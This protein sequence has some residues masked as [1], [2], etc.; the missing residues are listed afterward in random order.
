[1]VS[2]GDF[3]EKHLNRQPGVRTGFTFSGPGPIR[4]RNAGRVLQ[5]TKKMLA[6]QS[7]LGSP[8]PLFQEFMQKTYIGVGGGEARLTA[9]V[10]APAPPIGGRSGK[11][12]S[13]RGVPP[14]GGLSPKTLKS[15]KVEILLKSVIAVIFCGFSNLIEPHFSIS[16][17]FGSHFGEVAGVGRLS[18]LHQSTRTG[19]TSLR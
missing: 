6:K 13:A 15:R 4:D 14:M 17:E 8:F 16:P 1:M 10:S 7:I 12:S 2:G 18:N 9:E 3:Q 5:N 19:S 11:V